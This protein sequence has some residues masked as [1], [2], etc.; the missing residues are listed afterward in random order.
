MFFF[1]FF[2]IKFEYNPN[3]LIFNLKIFDFLSSMWLRS[4]SNLELFLDIIIKMD[5]FLSVIF[6]IIDSWLQSLSVWQAMEIF[7]ET[8]FI[9]HVNIAGTKTSFKRF[10][11]ILHYTCR[12]VEDGISC[13]PFFLSFHVSFINHHHHFTDTFV[14]QK[15]DEIHCIGDDKEGK[16]YYFENG[17][18]GR[19]TLTINLSICDEIRFVLL[20]DEINHVFCLISK[21]QKTS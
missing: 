7:I 3:A 12:I 13:S 4:K 21:Y 11:M 2:E 5:S 14:V 1:E 15:C 19:K 16:A 20:F 18:A 10:F 8:Y 9:S 17:C 6:F